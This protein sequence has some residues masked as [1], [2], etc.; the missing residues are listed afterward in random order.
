L[1]F[2]GLSVRNAA[3][4]ALSFL[5]KIKNKNESHFHL[6][7]DTK[8][9][10]KDISKE[11]ENQRILLYTKKGTIVKSGSSELIWL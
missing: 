7:M 8:V 3:K 10:T 5:Q 11:K 4:K 1:Y 6:E 2:L 9:Q